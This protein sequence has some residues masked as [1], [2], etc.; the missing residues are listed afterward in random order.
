MV[1]IELTEESSKKLFRFIRENR[2]CMMECN[3]IKVF[4]MLWNFDKNEGK[5]GAF[6]EVYMGKIIGREGVR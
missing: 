5:C 3:N 6:W 4:D 1:D 2:E